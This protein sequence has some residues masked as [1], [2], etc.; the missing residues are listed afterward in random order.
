MWFPRWS[1]ESH[2]PV[3]WGFLSPWAPAHNV[4][5]ALLARPGPLTV[6]PLRPCQGP[7]GTGYRH[8]SE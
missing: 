3:G 4:P 8:R 1:V 7:M 6:P 2:H 5:T